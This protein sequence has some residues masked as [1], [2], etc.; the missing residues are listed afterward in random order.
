VGLEAVRRTVSRS[1]LARK[2]DP[3][4]IGIVL[5]ANFT[6]ARPNPQIE[7][8]AITP[9]PDRFRLHARLRCRERKACGSFQAEIVL[10]DRTSG[11]MASRLALTVEKPEGAIS[12]K[13]AVRDTLLLDP[14]PVLVKPGHLALLMIEGEGF[15]IT[16]P[17]MP[18][19]RASLGEWVRV[20]D[21]RTHHSWLAQVSGTGQLRAPGVIPQEKTR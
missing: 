1:E 15:R 10:S 17:V 13:N 3:S 2:F 12:S 18:L 4:E 16:Q 7:V 21:P 6:T 20:S 14:G 9:S 8:T 11:V 5:P 19:K